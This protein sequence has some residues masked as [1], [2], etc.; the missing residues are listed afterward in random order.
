[1]TD[2]QLNLA[3]KVLDEMY[4][5]EGFSSEDFIIKHKQFC[6]NE[7]EPKHIYIRSSSILKK[8]ETEMFFSDEELLSLIK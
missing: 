4:L 3:K 5:P 1:M 7:K 2:E 6:F 8:R